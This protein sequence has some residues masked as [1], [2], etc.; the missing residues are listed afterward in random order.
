MA[1][2]PYGFVPLGYQMGIDRYFRI[3]DLI[4]KENKGKV[5]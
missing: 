2:F 1:Q 3:V 4:K 5:E